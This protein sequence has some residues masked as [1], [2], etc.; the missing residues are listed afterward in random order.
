MAHDQTLPGGYTPWIGLPVSLTIATEEIETSLFCTLV[1][2]SPGAVR[3]RLAGKWDVDIYK[4]MVRAVKALPRP[5]MDLAAQ[6]LGEFH[7]SARP[8]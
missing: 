5:G 4:E 6:N 8:R 1:G 3:V 7:H 2:E